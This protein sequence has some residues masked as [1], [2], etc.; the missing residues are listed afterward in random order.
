ML[1]FTDDEILRTNTGCNTDELGL[2]VYLDSLKHIVAP[3]YIEK[4]CIYLLTYVYV[5]TVYLR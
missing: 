1:I 5:G 2:M 4:L 3:T